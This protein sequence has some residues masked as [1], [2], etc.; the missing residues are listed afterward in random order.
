MKINSRFNVGDEVWFENGTRNEKITGF[1][2]DKSK[3]YCCFGDLGWDC[4]YDEREEESEC[5]AT[6]EESEAFE[7]TKR[8]GG[9]DIDP[10]EL[11]IKFVGRRDF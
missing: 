10:G 4:D 8:K 6:K 9:S 5:F 1:Y 11:R 3:L 2:V 7:Q